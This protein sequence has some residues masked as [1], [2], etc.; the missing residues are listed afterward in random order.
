MS[1]TTTSIRPGVDAM[2]ATV[3]VPPSAI[4]YDAIVITRSL[5]TCAN[6]YSRYP[7]WYG[8]ARLLLLFSVVRFI[9]ANGP[10]DHGPAGQQ[11]DSVT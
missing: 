3:T 1:A 7:D 9:G 10:V 8:S 4:A 5:G 11:S 2:P 6:C